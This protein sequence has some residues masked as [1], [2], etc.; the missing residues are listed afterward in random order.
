IRHGELSEN[1]QRVSQFG[2]RVFMQSASLQI[3]EADVNLVK[4]LWNAKPPHLSPFE[5]QAF[6]TP[7]NSRPSNFGDPWTQLRH[8]PEIMDKL[9][10]MVDRGLHSW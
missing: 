5:H 9:V 2:L 8:C 3:L 1:Y 7:G 10:D 6:Y 4:R